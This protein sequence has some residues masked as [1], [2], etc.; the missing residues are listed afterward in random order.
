MRSQGSQSV[1]ALTCTV[2]MITASGWA[3]AEPIGTAWPNRGNVSHTTFDGSSPGDDGGGGGGYGPRANP[4]RGVNPNDRVTMSLLMYDSNLNFLPVNTGGQTLV[5]RG[6]TSTDGGA[7]RNS[8]QTP[9]GRVNLFWD[10]IVTSGRTF[11]RA[12]LSSSNGEALIPESAV[13]PQV[14][15]GVLPAV[16]WSWNFGSID[17]VNYLPDIANVSMIRSSISFSNDGGQSF[18][19]TINHTNTITTRGN[20]NPGFDNGQ[21][22]NS[23]GDGTN[24]ILLS[25]EVQYIPNAGSVALLGAGLLTMSRR[26]RLK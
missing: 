1:R 15:G 10:E 11:I 16:Y 17:P 9:Q 25:Y 21:L 14:G 12:T 18:F 7:N 19:S 4:L 23:V 2:V 13:I 5:T 26:R 8:V 3:L 20:W 24:H 6:G 22:L